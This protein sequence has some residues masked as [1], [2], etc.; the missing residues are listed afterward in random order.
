MRASVLAAIAAATL[1]GTASAASA[2]SVQLKGNAT[3]KSDAL[4]AKGSTKLKAGSPGINSQATG[5]IRVREPDVTGSTRGASTFAP[6]QMKKRMELDS[7]RDLAPGRSTFD[8]P[9]QRM[10]DLRR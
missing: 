10:N 4:N 1:F 3:V 8:A 7:A 6:G 2:Q 5:G 9:G